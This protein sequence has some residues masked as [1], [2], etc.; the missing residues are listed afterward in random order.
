VSGVIT[1]DRGFTT[2]ICA[3]G[4]ATTQHNLDLLHHVWNTI[5]Y[6]HVF[7]LYNNEVYGVC[8]YYN[9]YIIV[10]IEIRKLTTSTDRLT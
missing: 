3:V 7:Y 4:V 5:N 1:N 6:K 8:L 2:E 9:H 10:I